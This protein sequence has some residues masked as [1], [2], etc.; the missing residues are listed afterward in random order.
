M[1]PRVF[2]AMLLV[3]LP[4]RLLAAQNGESR[5][6]LSPDSDGGGTTFTLSCGTD[7]ALIGTPPRT[8]S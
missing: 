5:T 8:S 6:T 1:S 4:I 3:A 2:V 7:R